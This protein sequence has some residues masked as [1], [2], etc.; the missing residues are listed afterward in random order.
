M[1]NFGPVDKNETEKDEKALRIN[2]EASVRIS[3]KP[4]IIIGF[5]FEADGSAIKKLRGVSAAVKAYGA[6]TPMLFAE[7]RFKFKTAL[8]DKQSDWSGDFLPPLNGSYCNNSLLGCADACLENHDVEL[9]VKIGF[10]LLVGYVLYAAIE[11]PVFGMFSIGSDELIQPWDFSFL[12]YDLDIGAWCFYLFPPPPE[13]KR[14]AEV[15]AA[16]EDPL[17]EEFEYTEFV[18]EGKGG[19]K[20]GGDS[21]IPVLGVT[22]RILTDG[23]TSLELVTLEEWRPLG[24]MLVLPKLNGTALFYPDGMVDVEVTATLSRQVVIPYLLELRDVYLYVD[25]APFN[26]ISGFSMPDLYA[27]A[28]GGVLVGGDDGFYA[29]L[30]ATLDTA[31]MSGTFSIVHEGGWSPIP[32]LSQYFATPRFEGSLWVNVN[33]VYLNLSAHVQWPHS[34]ALVED[35]VEFVG[36]PASSA[37]GLALSVEMLK[38]EGRRQLQTLDDDDVLRVQVEGGLKIGGDWGPPVLGVRGRFVLD[39]VSSLEL[40]TLEEWNPIDFL[41]LPKL[42]GTVLFYPDGSV[43]AHVTATLSRTVVIPSLLELRDVYV[44]VDLAPF[45]PTSG[46]SVPD[47]RVA[48]RG[49]L[50][51]GGD[52]GFYATLEATLDTATRSGTFSI[53]HEGGWSPLPA[54]KKYFATPRFEGH[55]GVNINGIFLNLSAHVQWQQPVSIVPELLEFIGHPATPAHGLA[56]SVTME[57]PTSG[58]VASLVVVAEGG[59]KIGTGSLAPPALALRGRFELGGVSFLEVQ[60]FEEWEPLPLLTVPKIYGK[61]MIFPSGSMTVEITHEP[62]SYLPIIPSLL[63]WVDVQVSVN[64]DSFNPN[65]ID[66]SNLDPF[67][68]GTPLP[69]ARINA[70]GKLLVGGGGDEGGGFYADFSAFLDTSDGAVSAELLIKHAGGWSPIP[71]LRKYFTTPAFNGW[72]RFQVD[73]VYL[74]LGASI[75]FRQ[76]ILLFP[77]LL[78]IVGDGDRTGG[79]QFAVTMKKDTADSGALFEVTFLA[80]IRI[81]GAN[82]GIPIIELSG[83]VRN[84]G[85]SVLQLSTSD[86]WAP[87]DFLPSFRIPRLIGRIEFDDRGA[88]QVTATHSPIDFDGGGLGFAWRNMVATVKVTA[89]PT[90]SG[91]QSSGP[92]TSCP[93]SSPMFP[94]ASSPFNL[95]LELKGEFHMTILEDNPLIFYLDGSINVGSMVT[96]R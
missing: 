41:A 77:G 1:S 20:I 69:K 17:L 8:G 11:I 53:V 88:V 96:S 55:I 78:E 18:I 47:L 27:L 45:N 44:D 46:S 87:I 76:P 37:P 22:G 60:T 33:G 61:I 85:R 24:D 92:V 30:E 3:I 23:T 9:S 67:A 84:C 73:G 68:G 25:V 59:V 16:V 58:S 38:R 12:N 39:G 4:S 13:I 62:L 32:S 95:Y 57:M 80:G 74:S 64:V 70:K 21:G 50:L 10:R 15:A 29:T 83:T 49:G 71:S 7:A 35:V 2:I 5:Y 93:P 19:L 63:G 89:Q 90:T 54:L 28:R 56:L 26:P 31:T 42:D 40:K 66:Y 91:L 6:V 14:I 81:G 48:A 52:D 36:Y 51:V 94:P 34:I 75:D 79:P 72:A 65:S 82:T 86:A 43:A